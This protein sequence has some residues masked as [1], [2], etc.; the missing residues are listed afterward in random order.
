LTT[1]YLPLSTNYYKG[2][3]TCNNGVVEIWI[4]GSKMVTTPFTNYTRLT[5]LVLGAQD[6][7]ISR[8][9]QVLGWN[10]VLNRTEI[11]LLFQYPYFNAGYTPVNNELQQIIN[12]A[13]AEVFTIPN[14][15][16][17]GHCDT[18]IT[19]MKNDGVWNVSDVYFNFAYNDVALSNFARINWMNPY[20]GLGIGIVVN[21]TYQ[22]NGFKAPGAGVIQYFDTRKNSALTADNYILNNAGRLLV[23]SEISTLSNT[24]YIDT[25]GSQEILVSNGTTP[26][27]KI[28]STNTLS[29]G[30]NLDGIGL[31]SIMR[32]T[33]TNVRLQNLSTLSARTQTSTNI[34]NSNRLLMGSSGFN[35]NFNG[36]ISNYWIG[37]SLTDLQ[38]DNF[39]TYYNTYLTN[40]GLT[41][42]A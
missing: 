24:S 17:L 3:I 31:K 6:N 13:N 10:R 22:T 9:K 36:C 8:F 1:P 11:D 42:F 41:A 4:D 29:S 39:R 35:S 23:M 7:G 2:L 26:A 19:E 40:I 15:T 20:G 18:L 38:I 30:V 34:P 37:A 27:H 21:L 33:S 16:I 28:N 12:R 5:N 14:A 32:D 25:A